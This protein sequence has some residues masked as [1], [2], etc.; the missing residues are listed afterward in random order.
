[1]KLVLQG[2]GIDVRVGLGSGTARVSLTADGAPIAATD[3]PGQAIGDLAIT[4]LAVARS[5]QEAG[6]LE[7]ATRKAGD[8]VLEGLP[9]RIG[10]GPSSKPGHKCISITFGQAILDIAL[11][12]ERFVAL[13]RAMML[14]DVNGVGH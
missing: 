8:D 5:A 13:A 10:V 3:V 7:L 9:S 2:T 4:M 1:M 14:I 11:P 6:G 12:D